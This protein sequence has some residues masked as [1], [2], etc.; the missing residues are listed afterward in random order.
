ML[1]VHACVRACR[2][3][4]WGGGLMAAGRQGQRAGQPSRPRVRAAVLGTGVMGTIT[5]T[6]CIACGSSQSC[7]ACKCQ[8]QRYTAGSHLNPTSPPHPSPPPPHPHRHRPAPR[9][10]PPAAFYASV[11]ELDRPELVRGGGC[12]VGRAGAGDALQGQG[13]ST[14]PFI[15]CPACAEHPT[16]PCTRI[17]QVRL[18][19]HSYYC[20]NRQ[21]PAPTLLHPQ[22]VC[23]R[24]PRPGPR[25]PAHF[26]LLLPPPGCTHPARSPL[27]RNVPMAV[28]GVGMICTANYAARKF[29]VRSAMP[30]FI[31]QRLCP[32]LVFVKPDFTKYTAASVLTREV[33][34]R[35]V[36]AVGTRAA[37][38][39]ACQLSAQAVAVV[40]L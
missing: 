4:G 38:R 40:P 22:P 12:G 36:P 15:H 13:G 6:P 34:A 3:T 7:E 39:G 20:S 28:G 29:G 33:F 8:M 16:R 37:R 10:R 2:A 23:M 35:C 19:H 26:P 5:I 24:P 1:V 21:Y 27:Q 32:H 11:E 14:H 30:G 18:R 25:P 9:P 31:A 17:W